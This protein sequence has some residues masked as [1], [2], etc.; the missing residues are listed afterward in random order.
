[1]QKLYDGVLRF[2]GTWR[3]YQARV[4]SR[5]EKYLADGKVHIVAAPGSGKTTLGIEMI[6]RLGAPCLILSPS[7]TIRQQWLERIVEGFLTEG[8]APEDWLS[9]DPRRMQAITAIT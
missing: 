1:M 4:L 6:R 7:I 5:A 2:K 8:N 3:D 9:H